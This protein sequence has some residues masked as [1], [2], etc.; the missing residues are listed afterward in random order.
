MRFETRH[1]N[2]IEPPWFWHLV[3]DDGRVLGWSDNYRTNA[4]CVDA[5]GALRADAPGAEVLDRAGPPE[6]MPPPEPTPPPEP[7][8]PPEPSPP[9]EP[10]PPHEPS[11]PPEPT[12]PQGPVHRNRCTAR[13]TERP[14]GEHRGDMARA[15]LRVRQRA[16]YNPPVEVVER[17]GAGHPDTL[18]DHAAEQL[19]CRLS[20]LHLELTGAVHHFN[21]DKGL[22]VGGAAA[23]GFGG[24]HRLHPFQIII[25]GRADL[26]DGALTVEELAAWLHRDLRAVPRASSS[27]S[28]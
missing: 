16:R 10:R 17:K 24:G 14:T 20:A 11:P 22:L 3:T 6:P 28:G 5:I 4:E 7:M 13:P 25:A 12:P 9:P 19:A 2:H 21:V 23:V 8:P 18:C 26:L 27:N 1:A 15:W